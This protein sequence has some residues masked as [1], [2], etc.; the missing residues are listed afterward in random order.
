[1]LRFQALAVSP[2]IAG[3]RLANAGILFKYSRLA[4]YHRDD[5]LVQ[6]RPISKGVTIRGERLK[7]LSMTLLTS[8]CGLRVDVGYQ[9]FERAFTK[10]SLSAVEP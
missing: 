1:M 6:D 5:W 9:A 2:N 4:A 10:F 7:I 8:R 3:V